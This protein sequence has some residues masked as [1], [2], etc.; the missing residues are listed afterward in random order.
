MLASPT[1]YRLFPSGVST[2]WLSRCGGCFSACSYACV[3]PL[4]HAHASK[5]SRAGLVLRLDAAAQATPP[6]V[7]CLRTAFRWTLHFVCGRVK[8]SLTS[9]PRLLR[10]SAITWCCRIFSVFDGKIVTLSIAAQSPG[11]LT[12]LP[13]TTR[14]NADA[15]LGGQASL[16][17]RGYPPP[18]HPPAIG[19]AYVDWGRHWVFGSPRSPVPALT[20]LSID[21]TSVSTGNKQGRLSA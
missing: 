16:D 12:L 10:K 14:L 21:S 9:Q 8:R 6:G 1:P 3:N 20:D 13:S 19:I 18:K 2:G 7:A 15:S 4:H 17:A 11:A 5:P